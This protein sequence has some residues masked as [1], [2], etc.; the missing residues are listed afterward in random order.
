MGLDMLVSIVSVRTIVTGILRARSRI[1]FT[2][3]DQCNI[4]SE[5]KS[6]LFQKLA[7]SMNH[8]LI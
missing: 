5:I 7:N 8:S 4:H 3:V 6:V 2:S 1:K